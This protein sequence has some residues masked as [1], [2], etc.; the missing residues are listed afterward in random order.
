MLPSPTHIRETIS[1]WTQKSKSGLHI[2]TAPGRMILFIL[3]STFTFHIRKHIPRN[4]TSDWRKYELA[5]EKRDLMFFHFVGLQMGMHSPL[6]GLETCV[7]CLTSSRSL[8][9]VWEQQRLWGDCAYV[10][11]CLC[12]KYPSLMCWFIYRQKFKVCLLSKHYIAGFT[13]KRSNEFNILAHYG[14]FNSMTDFMTHTKQ[15]R[16]WGNCFCPYIFQKKIRAQLFKANDI[17]S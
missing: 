15:A 2:C 17:I 8:L 9:H 3:D 13:N 4:V 16:S 10:Q 14:T 12:D 6:F 1:M 11:A 5:H 7:F